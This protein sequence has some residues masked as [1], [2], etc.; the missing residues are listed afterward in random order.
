MSRAASQ[1]TGRD[2]S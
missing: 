1:H 2:Q